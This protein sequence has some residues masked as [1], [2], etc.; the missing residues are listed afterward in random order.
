MHD[1][2]E[3]LNRLFSLMVKI[4]WTN[5]ERYRDGVMGI[6]KDC[7]TADE[8]RAV[9]HVLTDLK[10]CTSTDLDIA[11]L[12]IAK[13]IQTN[14]NLNPQDTIIVGV[15]EPNKTCGSTAFVRSIENRLPKCWEKSIHTNFV[16][17][18]RHRDGKPNLI[19]AD[20]FIGTGNKL[21]TRIQRIK[22][23]PKTANYVIHVAAFAGMKF[24]IN[25]VA[26]AIS[27]RI[28]AEVHLDKCIS[29]AQPPQKSLELTAGMTS[30]E[31]K[32]FQKP[33]AYS[34]GYGQSEAAFFLEAAN[35][36]NNNF[37]I[38]WWEKYADNTDRATLFTR[39]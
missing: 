10:Y 17:A 33:G 16:S 25:A 3:N 39:R 18:F 20:D 5:S 21:L 32:I 27:G 36:P 29:G 34:F 14:W 1:D 15:A 22:N 12:N 7:E 2:Q 30:I 28:H 11:S 35:I 6:L 37:P 4:K 8:F 23:N 13:V 19:I 38:L 9:E 26:T 24:G 31:K